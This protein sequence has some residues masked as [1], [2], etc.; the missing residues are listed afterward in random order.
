MI[1]FALFVIVNNNGVVEYNGDGGHW[2][3]GRGRG[4]GRSRG[5]FR[6]HGRGYS[7]RYMQQESGG[8]NDYGSGV[9]SAEG[10]GK[11]LHS[12]LL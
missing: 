12:L 1:I 8:Y 6:G 5:G 10:R 4:R 11:L 7:G 3:G 9:A 2:Y